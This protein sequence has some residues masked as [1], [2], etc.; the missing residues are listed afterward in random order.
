MTDKEVQDIFAEELEGKTTE[1]AL[2]ATYERIAVQILSGV[3]GSSV[4]DAAWGLLK[5]TAYAKSRL[6]HFISLKPAI[7][8]GLDE[9]ILKDVIG[10]YQKWLIVLEY[11]CNNYEKLDDE[12]KRH[13]PSVEEIL[14][15]KDVLADKC[16]KMEEQF[17]AAGTI[18][19]NHG[20]F[21][22]MDNSF[23]WLLLAILG[24]ELFKQFSEE[25]NKTAA[26]L[27]KYKT[28]LLSPTTESIN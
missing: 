17:N 12:F 24:R 5:D 3:A 11:F 7:I 2:M 16:R 13:W 28:A 25:F 6:C 26:L 15:T 4:N 10:L 9:N 8:T 21:P 14:G 23:N 22:W 20:D 27:R 19:L 1:G 18:V